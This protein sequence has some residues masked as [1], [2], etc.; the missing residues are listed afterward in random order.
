MN[1]NETILAKIAGALLADYS[2]IYYVNAQTGKYR[3]FSSDPEYRSL[4]IAKEGD[5]FFKSMK[6]DAKKVIYKDD[7]H[8]F[9]EDIQ[10]ERLLAE[11][12]TGELRNIEYRLMLDGKP[13]Y[14]AIRVIHSLNDGGD[15][16]IL[17]IINIEREVNLRMNA[18][19]FRSEREIYNQ[20]AH[21]LADDYDSIFYVDIETGSFFEFSANEKYTSFK[22]PTVGKD[23]YAE[24]RANVERYVIPEDKEYA[25]SLYYKKTM[26][27]NLKG[28]KSFSYK[29]RLNFSGVRVY[30]RFTVILAEDKKH[31][32]VCDKDITD[33]ITAENARKAE[34][35]KVMT[36]GQI[37][38]SLA[39]NYD[40]IYY[41]D[42]ESDKYVGFVTNE[43][44]G[45]LEMQEEGQDFFSEAVRN[46]DILVHPNDKE[47]IISTLEKDNLISLM[48]DRKQYSIDYRLIV[49]GKTQYTRSTVMR[50]SDHSH[51]II[52]VENI[53]KEVRKEQEQLKALN[54]ANELARR[55]DLTGIK[56]KTAYTELEKSVQHNLDNGIDYLPFAIVVCD[57]NGLKQINDAEGH[58]AGD[59]YICDSAALIC[60]VFKHSPVFRIGGDEFVIFL[61]GSDYPEREKLLKKLKDDVLANI[62]KKGAPV[63]AAGMSD[64]IPGKD[65]RI[66][67]VFE[68]A[69]ELMYADK[70]SLKSKGAF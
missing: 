40:V 17:G 13:V 55:D 30:Y 31:F 16:F 62:G 1:E 5:D 46:C 3:W 51:L 41:V 25:S 50:S 22:V 42:I 67:D 28:K 23:F 29:Y 66:S 58:K 2:S 18:E 53:D 21:S 27:K 24:T 65:K 20:I 54:S 38:E 45:K 39:S 70:R 33:E 61:R 44:Y 11:M 4:D 64:L 49:D 69:D 48:E 12:K 47:R 63:I 57:I 10:K 60:G 9:T 15:Y 36:F 37:A 32:I 14:H 26:L 6:E 56:N 7:V 52:G 35:K 43:I 8:I 19:K 68:R 59:K 34:K